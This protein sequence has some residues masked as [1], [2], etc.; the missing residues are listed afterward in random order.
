MPEAERQTYVA[1]GIDV[2][3][4]TDILLEGIGALM[5][6]PPEP[7]PEVV[8]VPITALPARQLTE[9]ESLRLLAEYGVRTV[10]TV[11]CDC[12]ADAIAAATRLGYPVVLKGVAEGVAHKSDLGLV[13]VGL[14]DPDAVAA[15]YD[16]VGC[17]RVILQAMIRGELEAIA[18]VTRADGV[19]LVMIAGLGGIFAEALHDVATFP[20][21]ASRGFIEAGLAK[22]SL[23]RV[24]ASPRWPH[25]AAS[26]AF[27]DLLMALQAAALAL[28]DSLQA[29]D[30]NPVILGEA[31]AV[32]VDALVIPVIV[33][34]AP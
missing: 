31:G 20:L 7:L 23:G 17:P 1:R 15:A 4:D 2:F 9:P 32:A 5:T 33:P 19:G 12:A 21:P 18:G 34:A 11:E 8:R 13:H 22:G 29:I 28:D 27:V 25:P 26:G 3:T 6:P 16:A 24:L 14:R 30:I 10:P